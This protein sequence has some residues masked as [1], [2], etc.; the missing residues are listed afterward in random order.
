[1]HLVEQSFR[2]AFV[3]DADKRAYIENFRAAADL[4]ALL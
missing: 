2:A 3:P 1:L 4:S